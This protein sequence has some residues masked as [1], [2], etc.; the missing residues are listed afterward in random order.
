M[1]KK[2][3][4][5][6]LRQMKFGKGKLFTT[7]ID[8][9]ICVDMHS[10]IAGM[11]LQWGYYAIALLQDQNCKRVSIPFNGDDKY[12]VFFMPLDTFK[13]W[14][15]D[16][17]PNTVSLPVRDKVLYFKNSCFLRLQSFWNKIQEREQYNVR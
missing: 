1:K 8:N 6:K 11:G 15:S 2:K 17:D 16:I 12:E 5:I 7:L 9:E 3:Q 14:L 4:E 10:V 13:Q